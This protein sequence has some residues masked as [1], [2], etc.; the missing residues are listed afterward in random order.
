MAVCEIHLIVAV[1]LDYLQAMKRW[2]NLFLQY[3]VVW[4]YVALHLVG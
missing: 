3:I 4:L 1:S 2:L